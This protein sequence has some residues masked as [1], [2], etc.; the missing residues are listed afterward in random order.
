MPQC[1]VNR[2]WLRVGDY[3]YAVSRSLEGNFATSKGIVSDADIS[4]VSLTK[5][6]QERSNAMM[7][8][9]SDGLFERLDNELVG[10]EAIR[11]RKDGLTAKDIT[12]Q[13]CSLALD[14]NTS[15]NVSVVVIFFD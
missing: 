10:K 15:D 9:A 4:T 6:L 13:L 7:I 14:K 11:M 2:W 8:N 5:L 3:Q 12:K 1:S